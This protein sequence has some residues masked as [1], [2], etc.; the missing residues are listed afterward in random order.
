MAVHGKFDERNGIKRWVEP[1]HVNII[2]LSQD[3]E[4]I[5]QLKNIIP[6]IGISEKNLIVGRDITEH[7]VEIHDYGSPWIELRVDV[8]SSLWERTFLKMA[9][10]F[11]SLTSGFSGKHAPTLQASE[12]GFSWKIAYNISQRCGYKIREMCNTNNEN[13]VE[14]SMFALKVRYSSLRRI[15]VDTKVRHC[16]TYVTRIYFHLNYPPEIRRFRHKVNSLRKMKVEIISDRFRFYPERDNEKKIMVQQLWLSMIALSFDN[17]LYRLLSRLHA[18]VNLPIEFANVQHSYFSVDNYAALPVRIIGCDYRK[19]AKEEEILEN[20]QSYL[21]V[22]PKVDKYWSETFQSLSFG[23]E[24][25][26]A[27]LFSRGAVVKDQLLTTDE[28]RNDFLTHVVANYEQDEPIT[29][30]VLER[31]IN[32]VDEM[33]NIPPLISAFDRIYN[34]IFVKKDLLA[35]I[36]ERSVDEGFQRVRKAII[37]PTRMLLVVPEL[38]MGNRVLR[39]FDESGDGALR[40]QFRDDDGTHLRRSNAGLYVIE[41]TVHNCLLHGIYIS[42]CHFVYLASSNSQMRDNGCYF[43]NDGNDGGKDSCGEPFIFSD[44]VGKLS[45]DFAEQIAEDLGLGKCVPS[46]VDY[47]PNGNG[48]EDKHGITGKVNDLDILFRPSQ[49]KFLAPRKGV[50]EIVKYSSPTPICLNR[51]LINILDQVSDMQGFDVHSRIIHRIHSLLDRQLLHLSDTLMSENR[52]RERLAEF[53]KR[54][55]V[56]YLSLTRGFTLTQE[57][58]FHSMLI[59]SV[60]FT[61]QKQLFKEQIQIPTN[62]GRSMFGILDETGLLQY[63]Q[64]FVQFTNNIS[65]KTP[66]KAAAK[67]I[68]KGPVLM[69]KNPSIVAGDVRHGPRP[70]TDE[71]AGSDLDGDE[72]SVIWDDQ[73]LFDHNEEP[74]NFGKLVR[75]PDELREDDVECEHWSM[76]WFHLHYLRFSAAQH[77]NSFHSILLAVREMRR[78][79]VEYIKQDSIGAIANA[80]LVN[81]D[82]FG[83]TSDVCISIAEKHSQSVDFPKTGRPPKPLVKEWSKEPDGK[84]IPPERPERWPDF[85]C[86]THEPS[87]VSTRLVG[88]LFRRIRLVHDVLIITNVCEERS[89]IEVDRFLKYDGWESYENDA[90]LNLLA[91]SA[92]IKALMDNYGIQDEGQLFSGCFSKIRNRI[93]DRDTD[94]MSQFNTNFVIERKLTNIFMSFRH[95]FFAEF[96][97]FMSCTQADDDY[98]NKDV[99]ERRYCKYPTAEMK[100][101]HLLFI[102][103]VI[104]V[105]CFCDNSKED[106][107]Y[108]IGRLTEGLDKLF[109][110]LCKWGE[111][112][113][114]FEGRLKRE[115]LCLL[116]IQ[117]GLGYIGGENIRNYVFLEQTDEI[118]AENSEEIQD[119]NYLIGGI[120]KCFCD[121]FNI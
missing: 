55:N 67:T 18:R 114:L 45:E 3:F 10:S 71:M 63:G 8:M 82:I 64:I 22:E 99:I 48:L 12:R 60:R 57:P 14:G 102:L 77:I 4:L 86:K 53:P 98:H 32:M 65:L 62:L 19:C 100:K 80:F 112:Q 52:C 41:T 75:A 87:Y 95:N 106:F 84:M 113:R 25:L 27:A 43:F 66:S 76:M 96:G 33:K 38:L 58:F 17:L 118:P 1:L 91:Y 11:Q 40:I 29:L 93:S 104:T 92:H 103:C 47:G 78:F 13:L 5:A 7:R 117:Y 70:H 24:Y 15:L 49:D 105:T 6:K 28:S 74:M 9:S 89:E 2:L 20:S 120:G 69:T 39:E 51:P 108:T 46:N 23:L 44:G 79:Y 26:V 111:Q 73:I 94:D 72:Y 110:V 61:L 90:K 37:T 16:G 121:F 81:S 36:Q 83:I 34:S 107:D 31:L 21:P 30:E 59:A 68:L 109:Y 115:H 54:I 50:I 42:N 97:G 85:M 116:L 56:E 88:Q 101:K 35:E 119:L